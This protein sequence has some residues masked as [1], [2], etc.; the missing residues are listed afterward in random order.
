MA[1]S[2]VETAYSQVQRGVVALGVEAE[3]DRKEQKGEHRAGGQQREVVQRQRQ[4]SPGRSG[5]HQQ[6]T[7][8][9]Q[10]QRRE[11]QC[12]QPVQHERL[13]QHTLGATDVVTANTDRQQH[14]RADRDPERQGGHHEQRDLGDGDRG[15]GVLG[16]AADPERI[17]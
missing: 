15:Q 1:L 9:P 6:V 10:C 4:D 16:D 17:H 2:A 5:E 7:A 14:S 8:Q 3:D 13:A 12:R 11:Q